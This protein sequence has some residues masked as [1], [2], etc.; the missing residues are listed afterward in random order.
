MCISIED[1]KTE[2]ESFWKFDSNYHYIVPGFSE[3]TDFKLNY[4]KPLNDYKE[5]KS[6]GITTRPVIVGPISFLILGKKSSSAQLD[7]SP[8]SLLP[9]LLP[10]Y[11]QLLWELKVEGVESVQIDEPILVLDSAMALEK[12]FSQTYNQLG[13]GSPNIMLAT[14]FARLGSS[15]RFIDQFTIFTLILI[16]FLISLIKS[17]MLSRIRILFCLWVWFQVEMFGKRIWKLWLNLAG[18]LSRF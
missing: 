18:K 13:F 16:V 9:K 6:V 17:S 11:Q 12:E 10:V 14:Y 15:I 4:N 2:F 1:K 8:I 3:E 5:A 7:F